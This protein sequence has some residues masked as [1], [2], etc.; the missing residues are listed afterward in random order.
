MDGG[1]KGITRQHLENYFHKVVDKT[2][3]QDNAKLLLISLLKQMLEDTP[4]PDFDKERDDDDAVDKDIVEKMQEV[5]AP[6]TGEHKD[7]MSHLFHFLD[8]SVEVK[9][10][11]IRAFL[12][13]MGQFTRDTAGDQYVRHFEKFEILIDLL[14]ASPLNMKAQ[15]KVLRKEFVEFAP[16]KPSEENAT[17][18]IMSRFGRGKSEEE[19]FIFSSTDSEEVNKIVLYM[20]GQDPDDPESV[21][22]AKRTK[23]SLNAEL[24]SMMS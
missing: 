19:K 5:K 18:S 10:I 14:L 6:M 11:K 21:E 15:N 16:P 17:G 24:V 1:E 9:D 3:G 22:E 8:P 23:A 12:K 20:I 4:F 2:R 7:M 13:V